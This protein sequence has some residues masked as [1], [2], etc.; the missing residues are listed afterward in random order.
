MPR[1]ASLTPDS[2]DEQRRLLK[3]PA[4]GRLLRPSSACKYLAMNK[5]QFNALVR[6]NITL[7]RLGTRAIAFDRLELD[8]WAEDYRRCNGRSTL[9][10]GGRAMSKR[11]PGLIRRPKADG[12]F[13]WHID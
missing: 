13:E 7:F 11:V 2:D 8:A 4:M 9:K 5:N 12:G 10:L 3:H 1:T 6:P